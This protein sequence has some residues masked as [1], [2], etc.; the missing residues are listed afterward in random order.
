MAFCSKCGKEIPDGAVCDCQSGNS[1][2]PSPVVENT[3]SKSAVNKG[4]IVIGAGLLAVIV[5]IALI[6]SS[7]SGGY[8]K[9]LKN[10]IKAINK[11]DTAKMLSVT[12][13]KSKMKELKKE[14]KDSIIDYDAFLDKMDDTLEDAME[15]LEDDYG[16]NVKLSAKIVDKKKVKGDDLDEINEDYEDE[17]DAEIKKAYKVKVEMT[18]KGKDD[19][20]TKNVSI[21]VVKVKGDDWKLYD[22]DNEMTIGNSFAMSLF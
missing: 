3:N 18:I 7:L 11:C 15:E 21:Y 19:K 1:V 6:V 16:K 20:D 13:P 5:I 17:Y 12:V 10:Y 14:M 2:Y 22:Y 9:P 4:F 8:K